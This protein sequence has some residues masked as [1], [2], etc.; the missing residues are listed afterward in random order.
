VTAA[1]V[2][3]AGKRGEVPGLADS[4]LLTP[5]ARERA[6]EE[7]LARAES[8]AVV[9]VPAAEVDTRGLHRCNLEALRRALER[10]APRPDYALT[11]GFGV[12]GTGVPSLA[13]WKG[14]RVSACIAAASV[15]AKVVRDRIMVDLHQQYPQYD[16]AQH[17]GYVTAAHAAALLQHG[18]CPEHRM[19]YAN[20]AAA[21]AAAAAGADLD[22]LAAPAGSD[23]EDLAGEDPGQTDGVPG[24]PSAALWS[25]VR[26]NGQVE[27][28]DGMNERNERFMGE[29]RL[30]PPAHC[31][32][33]EGAV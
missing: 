20:V 2:L 15:L 8:Y 19:S 4:K 7:V 5:A 22:E 3:P 11:D 33:S 10:L 29:L 30:V 28:C 14:D 17:K 21:L 18:P 16:F 12:D 13:V 27:D 9:V 23:L 1:V 31:E 26:D 32:R 24:G 25:P 6:Y